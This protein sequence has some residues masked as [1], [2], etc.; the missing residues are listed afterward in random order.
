MLESNHCQYKPASH[1]LLH[2]T[3]YHP[4]DVQLPHT[5]QK[6]HTHHYNPSHQAGDLPIHPKKNQLKTKRS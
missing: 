6:M 4:Q 3:Y 5:Y 2:D 1:A